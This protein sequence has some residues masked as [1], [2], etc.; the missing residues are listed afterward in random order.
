MS[1]VV[2]NGL[3][4]WH[5][6]D[7]PA[8]VLI[9]FTASWAEAICGPHRVEVQAAADRMQ[10]QVREVDVDEDQDEA[11]AYRVMQVP[12]VA[13][14][15]DTEHAALAGAQPVE[16]LVEALRERLGIGVPP[17]RSSGNGEP[18][19]ESFLENALAAV[20]IADPFSLLKARN[21]NGGRSEVGS[22]MSPDG[23]WRFWLHG[24]GCEYTT[25][26]RIVFDLDVDIEADGWAIFDLGHVSS[27][28]TDN[29][30]TDPPRGSLEKIC[31]N[32][33]TQGGAA[34]GRRFPPILCDPDAMP[35]S[36]SRSSTRLNVESSS[37][38]VGSALVRNRRADPARCT[39]ARGGTSRD[40]ERRVVCRQDDARDPVS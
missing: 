40:A 10:A 3:G 7:M 38:D 14:S 27:Y 37:V 8:L 31:A 30:W 6:M 24:L 18:L 35:P 5:C 15:G 34:R 9:H 28:A 21:R 4:F 36:S 33:V 11:N 2:N 29:G 22:L 25:P 1:E 26:A 23:A 13:V 20:A 16:V 17:R 39:Y 12:S 32:L 19:I